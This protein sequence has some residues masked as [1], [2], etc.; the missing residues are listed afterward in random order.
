MRLRCNRR[1]RMWGWLVYW[2]MPPTT[3]TSRTVRLRSQCTFIEGPSHGL[4]TYA[5]CQGRYDL[6]A[7]LLPSCMHRTQVW[8]SKKADKSKGL[9]AAALVVSAADTF[10]YAAPEVLLSQQVSPAS[11]IFSLGL[12]LQEVRSSFNVQVCAKDSTFDISGP[13][14]LSAAS[15]PGTWSRCRT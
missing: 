10:A 6:H 1:W 15:S 11:D 2:T 3:Q 5:N 14:R 12:V 13:C 4:A 7:D 9:T 8:L